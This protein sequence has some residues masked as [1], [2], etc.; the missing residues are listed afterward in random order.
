MLISCLTTQAQNPNWTMPPNKFEGDLGEYTLLPP[1]IPGGPGYNGAAA[2]N[3]HA[4]Y[5]DNNGNLLFFTVDEKVYSVTNGESMWAFD[6]KDNL[7]RP[8]RG[9]NER[10][11][12][13][14]GNSCTRF[15]ILTVGGYDYVGSK[16]SWS[17]NARIRLYM[18]IYNAEEKTPGN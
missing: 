4:G 11:I 9:F 18:S 8:K 15:A 5:S 14:M 2:T 1:E 12:L 13:P 7:S 10:L 17:T 16:E 3:L 6:I